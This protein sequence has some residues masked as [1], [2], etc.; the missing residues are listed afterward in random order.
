MP[1]SISYPPR[2]VEPRAAGVVPWRYLGAF[3]A[4]LPYRV[5]DLVTIGNIMY[6]ANADVPAGTTPAS[7]TRWVP[8]SAASNGPPGLP[9]A[10]G[11]PGPLGADG[12]VGPPG[13][14]GSRG[15][16][17]TV[18]PF[19]WHNVSLENGWVVASGWDWVEWARDA[20][21]TVWLRGEVGTGATSTIIGHLPAFATPA[22]TFQFV[23]Y[24]QEVQVLGADHANAGAIVAQDVG[25]AAHLATSFRVP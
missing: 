10:P 4:S 6:L 1:P 23:A 24:F 8:V 19:Y 20:S 3:R 16:P 17:A 14:P 5:G 21:G 11:P 9:G 13:P 2:P 12:A 22:R 18:G 15:A 25:K 7:D